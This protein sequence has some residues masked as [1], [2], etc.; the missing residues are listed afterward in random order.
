[1]SVQIHEVKGYE[2]YNITVNN[3]KVLNE[4]L[5]CWFM[6]ARVN[7]HSWCGD[8]RDSEP[9]IKDYLNSLKLTA[10]I[11]VVCAEVD[12]E[13]FRS[14]ECKFKCDESINLLKVPT[15]FYPS[16]KKKLVERD[17]MDTLKLDSFFSDV[18]RD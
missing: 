4:P 1:M 3:L 15:L 10:N 14:P 5:Y 2:D 11:N 9:V 17:C 7:G 12:R 18:S 6:G 8:C 16:L 13:D